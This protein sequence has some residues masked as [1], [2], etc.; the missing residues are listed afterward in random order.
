LKSLM[1]FANALLLEMGEWCQVD[2]TR[3]WKTVEGRFEHE[4]LSFLTITLADFGKSFEKSLDQGHVSPLDFN[5]SW[6]FSKGV[7]RFLS[8]FLG[9]VFDSRSGVLL[10]EPSVSAIRAIR[11][12]SLTFSKIGVDCSDERTTHALRKFIQCELELRQSDRALHD[13]SRLEFARLA[14]KLWSNIL[15]RVNHRLYVGDFRPKHGPGATAD[16]LKGN[17]KFT[18]RL[19]TSRLEREFPFIENGMASWSQYSDLDS[20]TFL[21]PGAE[22]P[23]KVITVPKTLK[24]PR[25]IAVEPT[26]MQYM[27]QAIHELIVEEIR[28]DYN[29]RNF[30]CYDSQLP[31]Q[32]L[33]KH[34]SIHGDL[35]TLD[36]SEASDR[37]SNE[38]V[39]TLL[40]D[41]QYL[42]DAVD[43]TRSRKARV[44][45]EK[46]G[47]DE[48]L[49]LAK[50]ASMG[51]ALCFPMEA[52]VF[53]TLVFLGIQ[54]S[55]KHQLTSKDIISLR[56]RV[57]VYGD[58]II[59]PVQHV[60]SV[61]ETLE[62]F[63]FKVNAT[64]SF[65]TGRFRESCGKD[66]YGGYDVSIVKV[67]SMFPVSS[68]NGK[69]LVSTVALRNHLAALGHVRPVEVLDRLISRIIPF[70]KVLAG[71]PVLGRIDLDNVY[72]V[73]KHDP[74]LQHP[75]VKG[76]KVTAR[77]PRNPIDGYD[78]LLKFYLK[79]GE[80][81]VADVEHLIHSGRP[82]NVDINYG[83]YARPY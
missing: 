8:G 17:Q 83:V 54:R 40:Q 50:F 25:I 18:N 35:A 29:A 2:T 28:A 42:F 15:G 60:L 34:G 55:L 67:R 46:L 21:E 76:V 3:D 65:W 4:G 82:V 56:G 6:G 49:R 16:G 64:K 53:T 73:H 71:S 41:H 23:V 45:N 78:A 48:T 10:S 31:N 24:T 47:F 38:H 68:Q 75:L 59:V 9:L 39:R 57:R 7:P 22:I 62:E 36:L 33:A 63:G 19:W 52:F 77:I 79:R 70:P 20:V 11:Q 51:S 80:Q 26:H 12:F 69:E 74:Y 58:D 30:L 66:Y 81:P 43:S 5:P 44:F 13:D 61:K 32:E 72:D 27:Q 37:V 14:R 1:V